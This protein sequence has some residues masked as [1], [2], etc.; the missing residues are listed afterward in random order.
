MNLGNFL[1]PLIIIYY[2]FIFFYFVKYFSF[3]CHH[4]RFYTIKL[5]YTHTEPEI[6]SPK[7]RNFTR[8]EK[9][10]LFTFETRFPR[11]P[12]LYSLYM[13]VYKRVTDDVV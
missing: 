9:R 10:N 4:E 12:L 5:Y 13:Y 11:N 2:V 8:Y 3:T 1:L 6:L 7:I